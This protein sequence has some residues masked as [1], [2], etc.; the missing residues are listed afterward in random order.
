MGRKESNQNI[1][2]DLPPQ[3]DFEY[4]YPHSYALL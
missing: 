3:I 4:G 1:S 2:D